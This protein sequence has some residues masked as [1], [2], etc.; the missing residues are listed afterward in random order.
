MGG[1]PVFLALPFKTPPLGG[2]PTLALLGEAPALVSQS[3]RLIGRECFFGFLVVFVW[4]APPFAR[5]GVVFCPPRPGG[6]FC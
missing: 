2:F 4:A 6:P 3:V 5:A 1:S